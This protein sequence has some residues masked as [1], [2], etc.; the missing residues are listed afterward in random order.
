MSLIEFNQVSFFH[1]TIDSEDDRDSI[2]AIEVPEAVA[3]VFQNL[4]IDVP[5]GV[6]SLVGQNGI[7]KTTFLLLAGARLFPATGS[8]R[9]GGRDSRDFHQAMTDP[10]VESERNSLISFVYQNMEFETEEPIGTLMETIFAAS[11]R[12]EERNGLIEDLRRVLE[13]DA[14][15]NKKLQSLS[16]GQMQRAILAFSL[17]YGSPIIMMDEPVFALEE[18]QKE[19]AFEYIFAYARKYNTSIYYSAHNLELTQKYSDHML[20]FHKGGK[21]DVGPTAELFVRDRLE[22]AYQV[23]MD[24]LYRRDSLYREVLVKLSGRQPGD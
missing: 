5:E 15:L 20:L 23:P 4:T 3:H 7:G 13:L 14:I 6:V 12:N 19:R 22:Q 18:Q 11:S 21:I 10:E 2:R 16:K 24:A 17:L 8:I 9:I 1:P